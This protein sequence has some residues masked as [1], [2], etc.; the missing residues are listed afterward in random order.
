MAIPVLL[1]KTICEQYVAQI[2]LKINSPVTEIADAANITANSNE[3]I[4]S[5]SQQY[6]Q[7]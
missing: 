3:T 5:F 1:R 2:N 4:R 6:L 7:K